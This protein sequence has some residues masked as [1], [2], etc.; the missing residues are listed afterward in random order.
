MSERE[1]QTE[2]QDEPSTDEW[3]EEVE[4]DPSTAG[5]PEESADD[6]RGG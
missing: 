1:D 3:V 6:L 4:Q 2:E 5:P